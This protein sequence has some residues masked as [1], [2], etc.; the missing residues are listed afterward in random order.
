MDRNREEI[1]MRL[2]KNRQAIRG[3]G[4]IRLGLFGSCARGE[5]TEQSDLDFVVE[6]ERKTFD[7]YMGL[8][9]FLEELFGC[10]VDL[11][12]SDSIKPGLRNKI[13]SETIYA[14]GL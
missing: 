8:K 7:A 2:Q 12:I 6:F 4:A 11:A 5:A 13:L 9:E 10:K 1:L 14:A 3:F